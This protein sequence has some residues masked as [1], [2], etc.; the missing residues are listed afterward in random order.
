MDSF[1][2]DDVLEHVGGYDAFAI[3]SLEATHDYWQNRTLTSS[4]DGASTLELF[5]SNT[6]SC[7]S[8]DRQTACNSVSPA[9]TLELFDSN[10]QSERKA[11]VC[12]K[13]AATTLELFDSNTASDRALSP[14]EQNVLDSMKLSIVAG[15]LKALSK[16]VEG[17]AANPQDLTKV[18][19]ELGKDFE[20]SGVKVRYS[21]SDSPSIPRQIEGGVPPQYGTLVLYDREAVYL[22]TSCFGPTRGNHVGSAQAVEPV[23]ERLGKQIQQRL[24]H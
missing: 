6:N 12:E 8:R 20:G 7:S 5:D 23:L 14:K 24:P 19:R 1:E 13:A 10:C 18:T 22:Y 15:D 9:G 11:Q 3:D 21:V 4:Q 17:F 16:E 2:Q